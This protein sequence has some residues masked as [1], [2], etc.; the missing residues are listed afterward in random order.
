MIYF[1]SG[2]DTAK[3]RAKAFA[4][5]Q[6]AR[7]KEPNAPYMRIGADEVSPETL[8]EACGAAGLFFAKTL[9]LI[10]DP[11]SKK[12]AGELL[13]EHLSLLA[14]STNPIAILAP[15]IH[16]AHAKK[17]EA[18]AEKVFISDMAARPVR[19]FN[20]ALVNALGSRD[21]EVLWKEVT[22]ALR[23]GDA[24][25][26]VHGLLHWKARDLMQKGRVDGRRFSMQ[27]IE[28]LAETRAQ[29][30]DLGQELERFALSIKK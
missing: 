3:A 2:S 21:G 5:V 6:A 9:A 29:A 11:F 13:L 17:I 15:G 1:F 24:P 4:W 28:L 18:K 8:S 23:E 27:L 20:T 16:P 10:D 22:K 25:E 14:A 26:A 7:L 12:E 19:G 30:R